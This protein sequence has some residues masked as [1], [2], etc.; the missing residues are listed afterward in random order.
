MIGV[1]DGIGWYK[2]GEERDRAIYFIGIK[3]GRNSCAA[4]PWNY[5]MSKTPDYEWLFLCFPGDV[6]G[7]DYYDA[8]WWDEDLPN[9]AGWT[10]DGKNY[11]EGTPIAWAGINIPE[12]TQ[13]E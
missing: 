1:S 6:E 4:G 5:D 2:L 12:L 13:E 3:D 10:K 9:G 8:G 7:G 11:L